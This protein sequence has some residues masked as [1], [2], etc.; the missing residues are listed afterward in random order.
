MTID[1]ERRTDEHERS[2]GKL[3]GVNLQYISK[4]E[5]QIESIFKEFDLVFEHEKYIELAIIPK[6]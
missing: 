4:A 3:K 6:K 1:L 2:L 5:T